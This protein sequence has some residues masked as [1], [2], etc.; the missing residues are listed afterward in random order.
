MKLK[1][2]AAGPLL[3][4]AAP[5]VASQVPPAVGFLPVLGI[6]RG[7]LGFVLLTLGAC[8]AW[9]GKSLSQGRR[10]PGPFVLFLVSTVVFAFVGIRYVS[11]VQASGDE[12][13]YLLMAQSLWRDHDLDL[14]NNFAR[15]DY[16]EY[17]PD[18]TP[19]LGSVRWD[20]RPISTHSPGLPLLLAP[21]Y[22]LGG[23][24]ACVIFMALAASALAL[25]VRAL[26][27][28]ATGD[29]RAS[30]WAWAGSVGPPVFF[31]SFFIYSEVPSALALALGLRLVL[32]APP[33]AVAAAAALL[34]SALPWL[35]VKM[36]PAA[37]GVALVALCRLR[38]RA[39]AAFLVVAGAMAVG[40]LGY[41]WHVF[42]D[43][44]PLALYG[45]RVPRKMRHA[46]P[47][48]AFAGLLLDG[49]FGLLPNA[50]LFLVALA[51]LWFLA[52][53]RFKDQRAHVL[54]A[55]LV[56]APV[57]GWR[58]WWAGFCPPARFLI[59]LVPFLGLMLAKRLVGPPSGLARWRWPLLLGG[60]ALAS[61]MMARPEETLLLNDRFHPTRVW[62][63]LAG[64]SSPARYLPLLASRDPAEVKVA[65]L[66]ASALLFLLALD[67]FARRSDRIDGL[68]RGLGL[69][70]CLFLIIGILVDGWARAGGHAE[71]L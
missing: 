42:H 11:R 29:P 62:E 30:L 19:H 33:P 66:W 7:P 61:F 12:V 22:A 26:A 4:A 1:G 56:L 65:A 39:L 45:S 5:V 28:R 16:R 57:L 25:E 67:R 15:G 46:A 53:P 49:S 31:Y 8:V 32:S 6:L 18:A 52:T 38:G 37:A 59:P 47:L 44:F 17:V 71:P 10:L 55:A 70:L 3:Q 20:G 21:V 43:P 34:L 9:R 35:H 68:F 51:G 54:V 2:F 36:I 13:E 64:T 27:S 48:A 24:R 63:A 41:H 58:T 40:Y 50:P 23:R 14:E 60:M 69:P